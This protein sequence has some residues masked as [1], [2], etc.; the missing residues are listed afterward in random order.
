MKNA[1]FQK[2]YALSAA[3]LVDVVKID[4]SQMPVFAQDEVHPIKLPTRFEFLYSEKNDPLPGSR[5]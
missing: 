4:A 2:S 5:L 3:D 1:R